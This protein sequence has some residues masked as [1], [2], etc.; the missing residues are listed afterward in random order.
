MDVGNVRDIIGDADIVTESSVEGLV[1]GVLS[2]S[3]KE[4]LQKRSQAG[5]ERID[6]YRAANIIPKF[7]ALY[8]STSF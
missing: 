7:E 8:Y 3:D 1:E 5:R 2:I 6:N 4:E